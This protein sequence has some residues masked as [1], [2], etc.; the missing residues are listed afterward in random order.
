MKRHLVAGLLVGID[1]EVGGA[2]LEYLL[3]GVE[4]GVGIPEE[5]LHQDRIAWLAAQ[6]RAQDLHP[7]RG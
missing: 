6:G 3:L 2:G 5:S 4:L 1:G 7:L